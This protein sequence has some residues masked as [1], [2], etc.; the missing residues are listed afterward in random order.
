[1]SVL[2]SRARPWLLSPRARNLCS[3][4]WTVEAR[5]AARLKRAL[6]AHFSKR[7]YIKLAPSHIAGVGVV[8][9]RDI[10]PDVDPFEAP[11][12]QLR[13]PE[14]SITMRE[15]ELEA[16]PAAIREHAL[17]FFAAM[18]DPHEDGS[19]PWR[20]A[21]G[22]LIFGFNATG[23]E[24]LDASWFVNHGERPNLRFESGDSERGGF[25]RYVTNRFVQAGEE[26]LAN[27]ADVVHIVLNR[28]ERQ[29]T[30]SAPT[31]TPVN[32]HRRRRRRASS[33]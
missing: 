12:A 19:V 18:D 27:Y 1:M 15:A 32:H 21:A 16:L 25:N 3:G 30:P 5:D 23:L 17:T 14:Q 7:S 28:P 31:R 8:A 4:V 13:L 20:D 26:L 6:L 24:S 11:N 33:Y 9:L 29:S 22:G 10:P 2:C